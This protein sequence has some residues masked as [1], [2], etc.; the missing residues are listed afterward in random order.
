M[1]GSYFFIGNI[2]GFSRC[3]ILVR[4]GICVCVIDLRKCE[5]VT[6][7]VPTLYG[8]T[9]QV[10]QLVQG[11]TDSAVADSGDGLQ[12]LH[13]EGGES[14]RCASEFS[15]IADV[16]CQGVC[17]AQR[18]PCHGGPRKQAHEVPAVGDAR[19]GHWSCPRSVKRS[20]DRASFSCS[21]RCVFCC[22]SCREGIEKDHIQ[23]G[24]SRD[25]NPS[26]LKSPPQVSASR[27]FLFLGFRFAPWS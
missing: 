22:P 11:G 5:K 15:V 6:V 21:H 23:F 9:K 25:A 27:G 13:R 14:A 24:R 26:A 7:V 4:D 3:Q 8:Q 2:G 10:R 16:A 20:G 19:C 1:L 17:D 12:L 18:G